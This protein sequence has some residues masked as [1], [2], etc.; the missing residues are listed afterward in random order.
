M[1]TPTLVAML[2]LG[3][4][5][6]L[7][8]SYPLWSGRKRVA[9]R[10]QRAN[11]AAYRSRLDEI[12]ADTETRVLDAEAAQQLRDEAAVRLLRDANDD[13]SA[14]PDTGASRKPWLAVV[15]VLLLVGVTALVYW[16]ADSWR[17]RGLIELAE[18]DP[19]AAQQALVDSMVAKLQ[20][21]LASTPEDAEGWAMLGRSYSMLQRH[22]EAADAYG[23]A[24]ALTQAQPQPDWLVAEGEARGFADPRRRLEP[25]RALFERALQLAPEHPKALWYGGAAAL[26]AGDDATA[27]ARWSALRRQQLPAEITALLDQELPQLAARS[28]QTWTPP[29]AAGAGV[30]LTVRVSLAESLR[31]QLKPGMRLLVFAKAENGPP[32]PL[33]VQRVADPQLPLTVT[34]DDSMAMLPN[35]KLSQF[36]RWTITARLTSGAGAEALSGDLEGRHAAGRADVAAPMELVIDQQ[37]P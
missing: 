35:M 1:N 22:A 4:L 26:Q 29:P 14:M 6:G 37:L 28:G 20:A 15:L 21:R 5:A 8:L 18:R 31:T 36:E 33:A 17:T 19:Q 30:A 16:R 34:L 7:R 13:D 12:D 3:L 2:L 25:Q 27:L 10:R 11:V 9:L 32:M 23:K 24:N